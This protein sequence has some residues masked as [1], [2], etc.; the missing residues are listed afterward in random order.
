MFTVLLICK[1]KH[2]C[3]LSIQKN[4]STTV[5]GV[6]WSVKDTNLAYAV[7]SEGFLMYCNLH[8]QN[9]KV[10]PLGK[11]S[12]TC[13]ACCPH[14]SNIQ[15]VGLK[16]GLIYIIEKETI[17]YKLRGHNEEVVSLSWCPSDMNV[18]NGNEKRDLLLASGAKDK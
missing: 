11:V 7:S 17:I 8:Y 15:A 5:T 3:C 13:V 18:L 16:G 9:C 1:V 6:D 12:A 14:N 2:N 10:I 4:K